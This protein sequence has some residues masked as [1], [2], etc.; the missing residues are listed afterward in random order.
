M[1]SFQ[2]HSPIDDPEHIHPGD[3]GSFRKMNVDIHA[4]VP[5]R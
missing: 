5:V 4:V 2:K 3:D 1:N